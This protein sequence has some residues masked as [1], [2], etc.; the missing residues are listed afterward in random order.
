MAKERKVFKV[1]LFIESI[2]IE[3]IVCAKYNDKC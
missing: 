2:N 3:Y 1:Y